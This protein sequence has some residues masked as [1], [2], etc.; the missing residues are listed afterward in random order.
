MHFQKRI[1]LTIWPRRIVQSRRGEGDEAIKRTSFTRRLD[2]KQPL[3]FKQEAVPTNPDQS[4][5]RDLACQS[6]DRQTNY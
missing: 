4:Q 1:A 6:E 3:E 2:F 5:R